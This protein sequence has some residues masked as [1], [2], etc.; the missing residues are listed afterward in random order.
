MSDENTE[1]TLAFVQRSQNG[2]LAAFDDLVR[3]HG[4]WLRGMLRARLQDWSAADDLAQDAFVTAF[5]KISG[6]RGDSSF[7]SWL[8]A[9]ALNHLRNYI[10]K[11]RDESVGGIDQLQ[12]LIA[13]HDEPS[14]ASGHG[15]ALDALKDCLQKIDGPS[16]Q[17]LLDRYSTGKTAREICAESGKAYSTLTMQ[18]H[19]LRLSL[20]ECVKKNTEACPS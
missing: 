20:G 17:L 12:A 4:G 2:D 19:R 6:F 10:R 8:R 11:R 5:R 14:D 7:E 18:L 1:S 3:T 13:F 16:R 9:I 15:A